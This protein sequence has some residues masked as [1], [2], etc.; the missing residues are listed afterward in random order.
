M[1][2]NPSTYYTC[3]V[4]KPKKETKLKGLKVCCCSDNLNKTNVLRVLLRI[5]LPVQQQ[6]F[7]FRDAINNLIG[8]TYN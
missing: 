3:N 8:Y 5:L 6:E 4:T 1:W 2:S 7:K